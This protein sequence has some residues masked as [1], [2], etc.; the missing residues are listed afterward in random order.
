MKKL[1]KQKEIIDIEE[2]RSFFE[3]VL[4]GKFTDFKKEEKEFEKKTKSNRKRLNKKQTELIR[5]LVEKSRLVEGKNK[6]NFIKALKIIVWSFPRGKGDFI[7]DFILENIQNDN[8]NQR[9]SCINLFSNW[10]IG[11]Q[12]VF[13]LNKN[14]REDVSKLSE[15]FYNFLLELKSLIKKY[16]PRGLVIGDDIC[17][18]QDY[19]NELKPSV[20][21]SLVLLWEEATTR[22]YYV[23]RTLENYPEFQIKIPKRN[24]DDDNWLV[25]NEVDPEEEMLNLWNNIPV[26]MEIFSALLTLESM[27]EKRFKKELSNLGFEKDFSDELVEE[28]RKCPVF[29]EATMVPF[30]KMTMD[31]IN[32]GI[33][34]DQADALVRSFLL[35]SSHRM[36]ENNNKE[37]MSQI[38]ADVIVSRARMMKNEPKDMKSF[39][40]RLRDTHLIIDKFRKE[41][42]ERKKQEKD[43]RLAEISN[44]KNGKIF[45]ETVE[46]LGKSIEGNMEQACSIAHHCFDWFVQ[47]EPQA[48]LKKPPEKWAA[49]AYFFV[50]KF[51]LENYE[52]G[53]GFVFY[54]NNDLDELGGWKKGGV[55]SGS[56]RFYHTVASVI[57]DPKLMFVKSNEDKIK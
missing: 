57:R 34:P 16:Q 4:Y 7:A 55:I 38:L 10:M 43:K 36:I 28:L 41:Y 19:L 2:I 50:N 46:E 48:I 39:L 53:G 17:G 5:E 20:Y 40:F 14:K 9:Q 32:R 6:I 49:L 12:N 54:D 42:C 47:T 8:G 25:E 15:T 18:E 23:E 44:K 24:Y 3:S 1:K 13:E 33:V 21:K 11:N 45:I 56:E 26:D 27:M 37:P 52:K 35:F 31:Y 29:Q 51:N 22:Y 30:N